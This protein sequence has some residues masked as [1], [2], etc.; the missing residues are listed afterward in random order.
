MQSRRAFAL[1]SL[2][3][4]MVMWGSTFVVT[5]AAAQGFSPM[6][7]A[8]LRFLIASLILVPLAF[9]RGGLKLLPQ[10]RPWGTLLLMAFAGIAAFS[11]CFTYAL[12]YGSASQGALIYA[13]LPAAIAIAAIFF[14]GEKPSRR[15]LAG[16]VLSIVG[17]A[18]LIAAGEPDT[19]SPAP[20]L[21]AL[22]MIGA[23]LAWTA[24]TVFAKRLAHADNL[25]VIAVISVLGTAMLL[26]FAV[27]EFLRVETP[28]PSASAWAG[29]LFMGVVASALAYIVYGYVL[30]EL[31]A[32]V[33]GS[34]TNLDPIVGVVIAVWLYGEV[35]HPGQIVGGLIAFAG[36]G[37]ASL[38][39]N[40]T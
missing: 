37:L 32:S 16:I 6:M 36:M 30:R 27:G 13:G 29:V 4:L 21:G 7:L 20:L 19:G 18:L 40:S 38:E 34:Y 10:P 8:M 26:P 1:F 25:V 28:A 22:W 31:D 33:V 3:L 23:V 24:Y 5:K 39:E 2:V 17:V 14:L 15:R 35:L 12:V 9:A 11:T